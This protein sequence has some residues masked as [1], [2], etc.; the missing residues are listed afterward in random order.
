MPI[1]IASSEPPKI[2][3]AYFASSAARAGSGYLRLTARITFQPAGRTMAARCR[4]LSGVIVPL[5]AQDG[6]GSPVEVQK[7]VSPELPPMRIT[8]VRPSVRR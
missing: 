5:V 2:C 3:L 6:A 1:S 8:P 7:V 4:S